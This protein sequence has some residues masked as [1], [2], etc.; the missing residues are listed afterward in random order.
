MGRG[1]SGPP[2]ILAYHSIY[3]SQPGISA[4]DVITTPAELE[5]DVRTL[6]AQG[7][8]FCT[9][10]ELGGQPPPPGTATLTFDD[11]WRDSLTVTAPLLRRLGVRATFY[12]CPGLF[13][14]HDPRM[15]EAGRILTESEARDLRAAG[16]ELGAHSMTHPDLRTLDDGALR[17][18]LADSKAAVEEIAGS[19]C[20]TLAYPFGTHDGRVRREAARTGFQ[21]GLTY[22]PGP[23]SPLAAPRVPGPL[24]VFV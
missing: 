19:E 5:H 21:L 20:R 3:D 23:W 1:A 24:T 4:D 17:A 13:G 12:L 8:S 14:N 7:Y 10:E 15:G 18:E 11:G 22:S 6:Q 2:L 9:A 16:M